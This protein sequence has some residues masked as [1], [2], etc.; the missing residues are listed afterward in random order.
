MRN[1]GQSML[2][3]AVLIGA[4]VSALVLMSGYMTRAFNA[5]ANAVEEELNGAVEENKP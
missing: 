5:H 1:R 3:T 2:E 4:A